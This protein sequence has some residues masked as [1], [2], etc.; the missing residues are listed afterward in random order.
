MKQEKQVRTLQTKKLHTQREKNQ[1][2]IVK[3]LKPTKI[4][5]F[6][7]ELEI[8]TENIMAKVWLATNNATKRIW[9]YWGDLESDEIFVYPEISLAHSPEF[10]LPNSLS[11]RT[12]ADT[13][14]PCLQP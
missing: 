10:G 8:T 4:S 1:D 6:I 7:S 12:Y 5:D 2:E 3:N 9:V 11:T 13:A 14:L